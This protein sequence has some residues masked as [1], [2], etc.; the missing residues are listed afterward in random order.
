MSGKVYLA[1]PI[2]GLS[3]DNATDWR[4][5]MV[6]KLVAV[7]IDA[8]SPLRAKT[9]LKHVDVIADHYPEFALSS[10]KGITSRDRHD[11]MQ[12]DVLFVN[13]LGANKVSIGTAIEMGWADAFRKPIV[14]VMDKDNVHNHA[15]I[16]EISSFIV[17]TLEEG[18]DIVKAILLK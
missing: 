5:T 13:V 9:Y 14:L 15:M 17:S 12:C 18:I 1:G 3:F 11:V 16:K 10:H 6:D 7:G 4:N 2:S 8:Y